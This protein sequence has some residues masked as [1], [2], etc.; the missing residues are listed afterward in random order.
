VAGRLLDSFRSGGLPLTDHLAAAR[1]ILA[2]ERTFLSYQRTALAQFAA[3]VSLIE[4]FDGP[5]L[6]TLGVALLPV[7]AVTAVLGVARYR[8][9][10]AL[11]RDAEHAG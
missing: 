5:F 9:M 11:I 1:T 3:G 4:F 2:N 8:R 10:R 7:A 6:V